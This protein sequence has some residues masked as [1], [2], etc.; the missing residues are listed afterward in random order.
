MKTLLAL[1]AGGVSLSYWGSFTGD[2]GLVRAALGAET[3][4]SLE[5]FTALSSIVTLRDN[6]DA[7]TTQRMYKVFMD[8]PW[9]PDHILRVHEKLSAALVAGADRKKLSLK[10][11]KWQLDDGEKWFAAHL[12]TTWYLGIY[13]HEKRPTQRITF[14]DALMFD[15]VRGAVPIPFFENTPFGEWGYPPKSAHDRQE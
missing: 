8:E 12:L 14:E 10:D 9:G 11:D 5:V 7:K 4:A 13:Y 3:K 2:T 1:G 15:A 6:L